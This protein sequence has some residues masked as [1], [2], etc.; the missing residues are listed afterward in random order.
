MKRVLWWMGVAVSI[1]FM[2]VGS[3]MEAHAESF[4]Q[5]EVGLG[6]SRATDV[7]GVWTQ[8][9]VK[10]NHERLTT[11]AYLAGLTGTVYQGRR[12]SLHYHLDYVYLGTQRA[13]C[14]CV[15]DADYGAQN[16][17]AATTGFA[18]SGHL[19][20]IALTAEPGY[21][22]QGIRLAVESGPFL[23]WNT[24][25][26]AVYTAPQQHVRADPGMKVGYVFGARAEYH[27]VS[28]SYR[29]YTHIQRSTGQYPGLVR[30]MHVLMFVYRF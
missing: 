1:L 10:D 11:P 3:C 5:A 2:F 16:Y 27:N 25:R 9:N 17:G 7:D 8:H 30:N 20:G 19:Q 28:L 26:E 23:F 22:W 14:A 6:A 12:W 4:F 21:T 15:S 24:W 29:Y 13:S 18:G